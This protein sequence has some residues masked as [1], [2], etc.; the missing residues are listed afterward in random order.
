[1]TGRARNI[2]RETDFA[3]DL[4]TVEERL[5]L[6]SGLTAVYLEHDDLRIDGLYDLTDVLDE[7]SKGGFYHM[8]SDYK[9]IQHILRESGRLK[10]FLSSRPEEMSNVRELALTLHPCTETADYIDSK[11]D[12]EG[13]IRDNASKKLKEL[14][15]REASMTNAM[16]RELS[17]SVRKYAAE[18]MLQEEFYTR[19]NGRFVIPVK[20]AY[21]RKIKGIVQGGSGSGNTIF[22]E[23]MSVV[24]L[25]NQLTTVKFSIEEERKR[26]LLDIGR[27]VRN[28]IDDVMETAETLYNLDFLMAKVKYSCEINASKPR[29][30]DLGNIAIYNG[31]H[32]LL[33]PDK[34]VPVD[35]WIKDGK[36]G[37][38]ITGPNAGG[39]S[40]TLKT[41]GL[42][43]LMAMYGMAIPAEEWS[44]ISVFENIFVD[45]G[46]F[47]SI[48]MNLSTFS[49][50][51][52]NLRDF[53][54]QVNRRT[55][56]LLDE[57]GVGTDPEEGA[58]LAMSLIEHFLSKGAV[59]AVTTHYNALKRQ[60]MD[61]DRLEN[62]SCLFDYEKI[63]PL[64]RIKVGIPGSSNGLL[65][66]SR[67]GMPASIIERAKSLMNTDNVKLEETITRLERELTSTEKLKLRLQ[68][69][70]RSLQSKMKFYEAEIKKITKKRD[71]K[72]MESLM[73]FE[74]E[75]HDIRDEL[76]RV[77]REAREDRID[78]AQIVEKK[79]RLENTLKKV[80]KER[81]EIERR[82]EKI[83]DPSRGD[84][85]SLEKFG[86]T[87]VIVSF[88]ERKGVYEVD[89][90]GISLKVPAEDMIGRKVAA[91][92]SEKR[93]TF[94][95]LET[96]NKFIGTELVVVGLDVDDALERLRGFL[97]YAVLKGYDEVRVVHGI[98]TGALREA[99]HGYLEKQRQVKG[100]DLDS[101]RGVVTVVR[102]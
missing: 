90:N 28:V 64:Y 97:A 1:M 8:P 52:V 55:L 18:G 80:S 37:L 69:E 40:V 9:H 58:S 96:Q 57:V 73:D 102:L 70:N 3:T 19:R 38:I 61:D 67:L 42:F 78:E 39:K 41:I 26:I 44:E 63:E 31:R 82:M 17:S 33:D 85:V 30:N 20:S 7:I 43:T 86:V 32:P 4:A 65:V 23:P 66:A 48:E 24:D 13:N 75:F 101:A 81:V 15:D 72:K 53:T 50:H 12:D 36:K 56:I 29:I 25:N 77:L 60:S 46:D 89:C 71:R 62:A 84:R 21:A 99:V 59:V 100:F 6:L 54:S 11:I 94:Y 34:V 27:K 74:K 79:K 68:D 16:D 93:D 91:K 14:L 35:V 87:G 10:K 5:S 2:A 95:S 83:K 88:D 76:N 92:P 22:V 51:I 49:G 45:I 47:Q 98:G